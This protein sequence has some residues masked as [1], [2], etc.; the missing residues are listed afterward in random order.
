[1]SFSR[2]IP[3]TALLLPHLP[4]N[5]SSAS[6]FTLEHLGLPWTH[7]DNLGS[8]PHLKPII[9]SM[10]SI[11]RGRWHVRGSWGLG[12]EHLEGVRILPAADRAV[13]LSDF[14]LDLL[15]TEASIWSCWQLAW[16]EGGESAKER[17]SD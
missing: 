13:Q 12:C 1:M 5:L 9:T 8:S 3:L 10:R 6:S 7:L 15:S 16:I 2:R 11:C 17:N 14:Q 4:P